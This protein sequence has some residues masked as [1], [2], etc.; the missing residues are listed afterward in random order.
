MIR[1]TLDLYRELT[2]YC[3]A[4]LPNEACGLLSATGDIL[5][6]CWPVTNRDYSPISFTMDEAELEIVLDEIER[7]GQRLAGMFHSHPTAAARPSAFDQEHIVF[8]CSYIIVSVVGGRPRMRS[9]LPVDGLLVP[10]R[11]A[12]VAHQ[13]V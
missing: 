11:I 5:E 1:I 4:Q 12:I 2:G 7:S 13:S 3:K 9:Y 10:E 6:T 8:A